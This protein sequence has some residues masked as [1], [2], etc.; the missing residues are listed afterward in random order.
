MTTSDRKPPA[1]NQQTQP[2]QIDPADDGRV[3]DRLTGP[4]SGPAGGDGP[5]RITPLQDM[6]GFRIDGQLDLNG[7][8]ELATALAAA[9]ATWTHSSGDIVV[10]LGGAGSVDV[11]GMRLLVRAARGLPDGRVLVLRGVPPILRRLLEI[12]GW[13]ATPGLR[14]EPGTPVG[15]GARSTSSRHGEPP[16]AVRKEGS[17]YQTDGVV[18]AP[19]GVHG[20][21]GG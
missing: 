1:P 5:L 8:A 17:A 14:V 21:Q 15:E 7:R 19:R 10:D 4:S 3:Q 18:A 2:G 16:I 9:L 20:Q 13:A 12:T 11:G 6:A